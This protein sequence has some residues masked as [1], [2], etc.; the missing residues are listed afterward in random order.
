MPSKLIDWV[1]RDTLWTAT[2]WVPRFAPVACAE[3]PESDRKSAFVLGPKDGGKWSA[4]SEKLKPSRRVGEA[5]SNSS[6]R[7]YRGFGILVNKERLGGPSKVTQ[8]V[9]SKG[10]SK[11]DVER[12]AILK[13][14]I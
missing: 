13:V 7:G 11:W 4:P 14:K 6:A 2:E 1:E 5:A 10:K 3:E 8:S 12:R 9:D